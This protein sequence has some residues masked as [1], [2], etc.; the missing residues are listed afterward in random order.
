V[1]RPF[2]YGL[3]ATGYQLPA[4]G[5]RYPLPA[6]SSTTVRGTHTAVCM[7]SETGELPVVESGN[8]RNSPRNQ[9]DATHPPGG[10][11]ASQAIHR[12]PEASLEGPSLARTSPGSYSEWSVAIGST[13]MA[14]S[15]GIQLA[16]IATVVRTRVTPA[17]VNRS[18]GDTP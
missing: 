17:N 3:P 10:V 15:A 8:P 13:R 14:R 2:R 6:V 18:P 1:S 11:G 5:Y 12:H 7:C 9:R 4:T 16:A